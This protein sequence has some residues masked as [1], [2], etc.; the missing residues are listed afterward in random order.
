[1]SFRC[2]CLRESILA[3][4]GH[5]KSPATKVQAHQSSAGETAVEQGACNSRV[6]PIFKMSVILTDR[7][8]VPNPA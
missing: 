1:M 7:L 8:I 6:A 4:F 2:A 3:L 5:N